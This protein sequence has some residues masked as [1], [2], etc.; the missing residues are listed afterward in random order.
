M[1]F[2]RR[3]NTGVYKH[4]S[5]RIVHYHARGILNI[6]RPYYCS[7]T[8]QGLAVCLSNTITTDLSFNSATYCRNKPHKKLGVHQFTRMQHQI[9]ESRTNKQTQ[10]QPSQDNHWPTHKPNNARRLQIDLRINQARR[11]RYSKVYPSEQS[12]KN[13]SH[14]SYRIKIIAMLQLSLEIN[15]NVLMVW[16]FKWARIVRWNKLQYCSTIMKSL[17]QRSML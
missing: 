16:Y 3:S 11:E 8:A 4:T 13:R 17:L 5:R 1:A 15:R 6:I 10:Q 12:K 2:V 7:T 9:L 14:S